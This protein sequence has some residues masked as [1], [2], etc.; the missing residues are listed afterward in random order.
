[1][2]LGIFAMI[3]FVPVF[4]A[5]VIR[6][7]QKEQARREAEHRAVVDSL[8]PGERIES[9]SGIHG[10]IVSVAED[11]VEVEIAAGVVVTMARQAIST[12]IDAGGSDDGQE[13]LVQQ[14]SRTD[15]DDAAATADGE[16]R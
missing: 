5:L 15:R 13:A 6:P 12:K 3:I 11:T 9:F 14:V 16:G 8:E 10:T 4:W 7:Q 2:L 1:M